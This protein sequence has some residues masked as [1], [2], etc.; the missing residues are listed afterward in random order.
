MAIHTVYGYTSCGLM[1]WFQ[2]LEFMQL[3]DGMVA[4]A[5]VQLNPTTLT[6]INGRIAHRWRNV[7]AELVSEW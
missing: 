5:C 7:G 2:I 3:V 1:R 6:Q 4:S